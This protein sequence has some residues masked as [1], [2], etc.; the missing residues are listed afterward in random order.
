MMKITY[1]WATMQDRI[2]V[3]QLLGRLDRFFPIPLSEK[4]DLQTLTDKLFNKGK[5]LLALDGETPVGLIGFYAN[6]A[7]TR[8]A[9]VSV[10][11]VSEAYRGRGIARELLCRAMAYSRE[12]GMAECRLYTH[13][14]NTAAIRLYEGLSFEGQEDAARPAD[15][16]FVKKL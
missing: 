5:V 8:Q 16:L 15:I 14:S 6:D 1:Q 7:Q 2:A 13:R 9:Y 11:G 3:W 10:V 12:V 4:T